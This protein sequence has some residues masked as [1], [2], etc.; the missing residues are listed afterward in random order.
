MHTADGR[1]ATK[2]DNAPF[3]HNLSS[4]LSTKAGTHEHAE[5]KGDKARPEGVIHIS[6]AYHHIVF[7]RF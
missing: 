6:T 2:V 5:N 3:I 7:F 1:K 4:E